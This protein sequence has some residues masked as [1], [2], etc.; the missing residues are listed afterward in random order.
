MKPKQ[1]K[2]EP[3]LASR[4]LIAGELGIIR[5]GAVDAVNPTP[6]WRKYT[7]ATEKSRRA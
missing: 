6:L 2:N 4:S 5:A 3:R 7:G 1:T